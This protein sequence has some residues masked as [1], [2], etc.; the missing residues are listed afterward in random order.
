MIII[1]VGRQKDGENKCS[2]CV[3]VLIEMVGI[4]DMCITV[5]VEGG[6]VCVGD[7]MGMLR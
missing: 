3:C 2:V 1:C 6:V 5:C 7:L 4:S